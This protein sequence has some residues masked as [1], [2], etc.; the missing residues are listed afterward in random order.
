[1]VGGLVVGFACAAGIA[2]L[3]FGVLQS[4]W[5]DYAAAVPDRTYTLPM[6]WSRL[7]IAAFLTVVSAAASALVAG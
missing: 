1:M 3:G 6:L 4:S 5:P 7:G 2:R